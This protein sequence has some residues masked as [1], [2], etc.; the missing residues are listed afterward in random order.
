MSLLASGFDCHK[1]CSTT[2]VGLGTQ[3]RGGMNDVFQEPFFSDDNDS[4]PDEDSRIYTPVRKSKASLVD[5]FGDGFESESETRADKVE[6][7]HFK[8]GSRVTLDNIFNPTSEEPNAEIQDL[9]IVQAGLKFQDVVKWHPNRIWHFFMDKFFSDRPIKRRRLTRKGRCPTSELA[10][11]ISGHCPEKDSVVITR[12]MKKDAYDWYSKIVAKLT[13]ETWRLCKNKMHFSWKIADVATDKQKWL[14]LGNFIRQ[15]RALLEHFGM[16]AGNPDDSSKPASSKQNPKI[17]EEILAENCCGIALTYNTDAGLLEPETMAAVQAM[18][19]AQ[20]FIEFAKNNP[21]HK[22]LFERFWDFIDKLGK[23]YRWATVGAC[24]E[25]SENAK[26]VGRIHFHAYMGSDIKGGP[27]SMTRI[28]RNEVASKDL[29]WNGL[30]PCHTVTKTQRTRPLT[31]FN[32]VVNG[33]YY[34]VARKTTSI[35]TRTTL[36]P[37]QAWKDQRVI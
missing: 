34:V 15:D 4:E 33:H 19:S 16:Q 26:Q 3:L 13:H 14:V 37:I 17:C 12:H 20:D 32:A 18:S 29:V 21:F 36:E 27:A 31:I 22:V 8:F 10:A 11:V 7:P 6:T 1:V 24:M 30:K 9:P 25:L 23:T 35:V 5:I 28:T 2:T